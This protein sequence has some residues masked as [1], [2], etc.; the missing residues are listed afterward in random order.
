MPYSLELPKS[1]KNDGWKVKIRG[2]ERLEEPHV[3]I[4]RGT[5]TWRLG[6]RDMR[7]LRPGKGLRD[8]EPVWEVIKNNLEVLRREWDRMYPKNSITSRDGDDDE[9]SQRETKPG[10]CWS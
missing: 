2:K 9:S 6:L 4:T 5:D 10:L 8:I 3:T 7:L 1:L